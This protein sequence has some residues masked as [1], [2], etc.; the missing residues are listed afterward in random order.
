MCG[1][2]IGRCVSSHIA[3]AVAELDRR[4][5]CASAEACASVA[6]VAAWCASTAGQADDDRCEAG[7]LEAA[8]DNARGAVRGW[9]IG[10]G[11]VRFVYVSSRCARDRHSANFVGG[12]SARFL[13]A[14]RRSSG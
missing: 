14:N 2:G 12:W 8:D 6:L 4:R 11:W 3:S 13:A 5:W 10:G 1:C 9:V 7:A